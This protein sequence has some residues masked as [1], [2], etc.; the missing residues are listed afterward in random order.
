MSKRTILVSGV[1][2][3]SLV[4]AIS[5]SVSLTVAQTNSN[6]NTSSSNTNASSSPSTALP[7]RT[8]VDGDG[9]IGGPTNRLEALQEIQWMGEALAQVRP[10]PAPPKRT[11]ACPR[12]ADFNGNG[13]RDVNDVI[14]Y[15]NY[16]FGSPP[17]P[18]PATQTLTT[19]SL[20]SPSPTPS[21]TAS[22]TPSL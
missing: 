22:P 6:T 18:G 8:D 5:L 14:A 7:R 17:G 21:P 16:A 20:P 13:I 19:C 4:V 9:Q 10:I 2:F 12:A 11:L 15:V 3:A 1:I